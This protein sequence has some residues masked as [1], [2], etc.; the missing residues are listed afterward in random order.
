MSRSLIIGL[1]ITI[2]II[3]G[4]A[5]F[6]YIS[7]VKVKGRPAIDAVPNDAAL[8]L[9]TKNIQHVLASFYGTDMWKDLRQNEVIRQLDH[10][11][12]SIDSLIYTNTDLQSVLAENKA[13]I[14]FHS[15]G[16]MLNLLFIAETG[17][18]DGNAMITWITQAAKGKAV[19]RVFDK[20]T[21]YDIFNGQQELMFSVAFRDRLLMIS[22]D[23]TLV[24]ESIRKLKYH[25]DN[26]SK[27][28]EQA[29]SLANISSDLN[30]YVNYQQLPA[31][32]AYVNKDEYKDMYGFLK[33]FADWSVLDVKIDPGHLG[34][35]GVTFTD[36]SLFQ[37]LDLFKSQ[38]PVD[39]DLSA[40]MPLSTAYSVQFSF[41]NYTQFNSDLN[42]YLQHTGKLDAYLKYGDSIE[43]KYHISLVEKLAPQ[44]GNTALLGL[45]E[46][47]G[48]DY[49][50]Q[51]FAIL[52]FKDNKAADEVFSS[53]IREIEKRGEADSA[54]ISYNNRTINRLQLGNVFK[55]FYGH[56]FEDLESP[57]YVMY[58]NAFILA[59]DL[60]V[61]KS[62]VDE[63]DNKNTLAANES[64]QA[65]RKLSASS[66]NINL[67]ISPGK[68]LQLPLMYTNDAFISALSRFRYDFKKFEYINIQYANSSNNSFFTTVNLKFNP[69]FKEETKMLWMAKL[70][71]TFDMQPAIVFNSELKLPCILVQDV[72]NT[73]YYISNSGTVLWKTKLSGKINSSVFEVDANKNGEISYLFSTNKQACLISNKGI[74]LLGYPVR[75]PG[76]AT[77]GISLFDFYGDS[78]FQFFVPLESNKIMGYQLNG[79]PVAGWNPKS[80]DG[81]IGRELGGFRLASGA[82][83]C[84]A[85]ANGQLLVY[86]LKAGQP[87]L[88]RPV[89]ILPGSRAY[90][91]SADTSKAEIWV[92][93]TSGQVVQYTFG[94][95]LGASVTSVVTPRGISVQNQVIAASSGYFI[96][97]PDSSGF[98]LFSSDGKKVF[99]QNYTDTLTTQPFFTYT[100]EHIP[101]VGYTER[102]SQKIN[103]FDTTG[104]L[105][106]FFPLEGITPFVTG[107]L[108]L[109]NANYTVCGDLHNNIRV[110]RLK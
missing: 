17:L 43:D 80:I 8:V 73:V 63:L 40:T 54:R 78:S 101:M 96:L 82:Y 89:A 27:G 103:W 99:G 79:K 3:S 60:G 71:T 32:L 66:G 49:K 97:N 12:V 93:D 22:Q 83:L 107:D 6:F 30:V 2:A 65:H 47:P 31:L 19:K 7:F 10:T 56:V 36:D 35:S 16:T 26:P 5:T 88:A 50:Q 59:N 69:S 100:K 20:E 34:I 38:S 33:V 24:E 13:T 1:I 81:R 86:G 102:V 67:F 64:Y 9:E 39:N 37:F 11:V 52:Q 87:K 18:S 74:N 62:I 84:G 77:A 21:V 46:P 85:S 90:S 72:L 58:N 42:E 15:N 53:C 44:I 57:F 95:S 68:C 14:S 108:L 94:S 25:V 75:F 23:G 98:A 110:Y 45:Y 92:T 76:T 109:N 70:D 55:L 106:P 61:L 51:L 41:S 4:L 105:Y 28:F 48:S 29:R 91:F 104:K